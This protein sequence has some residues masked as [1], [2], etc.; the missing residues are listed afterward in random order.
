MAG[1]ALSV[2]ATLSN[3]WINGIFL[4][5]LWQLSRFPSVNS[6]QEGM[7]SFLKTPSLSKANTVEDGMCCVGRLS[8]H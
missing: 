5:F 8:G 4:L 2:P 7:V 1:H 6:S 3:A